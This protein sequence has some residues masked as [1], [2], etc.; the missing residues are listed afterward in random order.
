LRSTW[1]LLQEAQIAPH[2]IPDVVDPK[3]QHDEAIE[4]KAKGEASQLLM[5]DVI[6]SAK[7]SLEHVRV[8]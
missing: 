8:N 3:A 5:V 1:E 4:T 2:Q 6:T 7:A